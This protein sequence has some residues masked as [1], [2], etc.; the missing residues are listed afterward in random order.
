MVLH[1]HKNAKA[2]GPEF[3]L[4]WILILI[5]NII[6]TKATYNPY[7]W[8]KSGEVLK[9]KQLLNYIFTNPVILGDWWAP[10]ISSWLEKGV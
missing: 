10:C 6:I 1:M 5:K 9:L 2:C 4:V 7:G 3:S 8:A